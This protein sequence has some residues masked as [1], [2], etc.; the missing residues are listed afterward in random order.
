MRYITV[1]VA[2]LAAANASSVRNAIQ[3]VLGSNSAPQRYLIETAPGETRWILEDEKW[4]LRRV[5]LVPLLL[6]NGQS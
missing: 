3:K 6:G 2:S 4:E 5:R 1:F